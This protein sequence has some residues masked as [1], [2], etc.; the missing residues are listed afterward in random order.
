[1]TVNPREQRGLVIAATAKIQKKSE[2]LWTVPSA[3]GN[4]SYH[5]NP[6][7]KI[8]SCLDCMDGGNFCKHLHAVRFVIQRELQFGEDG[9]VTETE[10]LTIQAVKRTIYPQ[11]WAAYNSAQTH[12]KEKFLSLLHELCGGVNEPEE[13]KMGRPRLSLRDAI[14]TACYKVYSTVSCRRFM[15]DLRDAQENGYIE[16][17]PHFNSVLN[18][19]ENP[20]LTPILRDLIIE[21]SLPLKAVE[22]DFACDSS[23]FTTSRFHRWF[24]HK[25]GKMRQEHD[26]VKVHIMC[27]V[28]TNVVTAV[29]IRD[30]NTNDSPMLPSLLAT[31]KERFTVKELSGDK[32]YASAANFMAI[33]ESGATPYIA[34]RQG[35]TG[36]RTGGAF[37]RAFHYFCLNRQEFMAHY[38]K[39]SNVE[40]TFSA[41]K[42]KFGDYVRSKT[43]TAMVNES[44]C[45]ILCHNIVVLIHEAHE[46]GIAPTF[47]ADSAPA[48]KLAI[49]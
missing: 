6:E 48:Q 21:S 31:T 33:Q 10:T 16:K 4:G 8:C 37:A 23:G 34:F 3:Q 44:L 1:M 5:V 38:H 36:R 39:R 25:Y 41:I 29:E 45:K 15:T 11:Q 19:L 35:I 26:W 17:T 46:L 7:K 43:N 18:Y 22:T 42:R 9:T 49:I 32:Q 47:W 14:F 20:N 13:T 24:D 28:K 40:S 30:R 12:E 2:H 27:G